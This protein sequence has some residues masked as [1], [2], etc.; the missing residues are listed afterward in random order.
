MNVL[1]DFLSF[2]DTAFS[3][4]ECS[5]FPSYHFPIPLCLLLKEKVAMNDLPSLPCS[6][7]AAT[8]SLCCPYSFI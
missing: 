4:L 5:S 3:D 2:M 7:F 1:L 8:I 6:V